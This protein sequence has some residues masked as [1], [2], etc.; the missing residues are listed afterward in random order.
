MRTS[1]DRHKTPPFS[2]TRRMTTGQPCPV[3]HGPMSI[4][5]R[6][7]RGPSA[8]QENRAALISAARSVFAI[9]GLHAPLSAVAKEAGVGQGSLYRHF[10]T[11]YSLAVAVF[12]ENVD[13]LESL[14]DR[15]GCTLGDLLRVITEQAIV[16]TAFFEM[17]EIEK[18]DAAGLELVDRIGHLLTA[19]L[20]RAHIDGAAPDWVTTNDV[21]LSIAMLAGALAK[22][23][24]DDRREVAERVWM[25]L[26]LTPALPHSVAPA[27]ET[28]QEKEAIA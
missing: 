17:I 1:P 8:A 28:T 3:Y 19:A 11:R 6:A 25:L 27:A 12:Q 15:D 4:S 7:N 18:T 2:D 5:P 13:E 21:L 20:D 14:A 22:T 26:P 9:R 16:S 24:H 10:P 23:P